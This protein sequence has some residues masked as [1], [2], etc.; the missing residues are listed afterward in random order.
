MFCGQLCEQFPGFRN[1]PTEAAHQQ[2][3]AV[4]PTSFQNPT[5][6]RYY[7]VDRS[8]HFAAVGKDVEANLNQPCGQL[9]RTERYAQHAQGVA[10]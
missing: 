7:A 2:R 5:L 8:R 9:L 4:Y 3:Y 1:C 6:D 10:R